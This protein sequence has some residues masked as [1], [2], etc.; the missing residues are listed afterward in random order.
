MSKCVMLTHTLGYIPTVYHA[1]RE[2]KKE[3][4]EMMET[5]M[6]EKVTWER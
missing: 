4:L 3:N 2:V 5:K 6:E 1:H